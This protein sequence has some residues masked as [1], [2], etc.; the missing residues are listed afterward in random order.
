MKYLC[1]LLIAL[2]S[3][4]AYSQKIWRGLV[5]EKEN[6][7]S[8]YDKK[9]QYPYSAKIEHDIVASMNN[10]VYGPYTGKYFK[11]IKNTDIE[12]IVASSEAHNSGL[13]RASAALRAQFSQDLLN[14]TLASPA[15]NRCSTTGKCGLDAG[16][17]MPKINKCWFANRVVKI[18]QKYS[19]S[20]DSQEVR[21]LEAV[22]SNC[23]SFDMIYTARG[24]VVAT[25]APV[26]PQVQMVGQENA[27]AKYDDNDNGRIT[28]KEARNHGIAPVGK[29]HPAYKHMNDRDND[30]WVCE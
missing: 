26:A 5:V 15:V 10:Q 6:R 25:T 8:P 29:K 28:C 20:V 18:K 12:H 14:L 24:S 11:S 4:N 21:S 27:L 22:L 19:L 17:W 9:K 23:T 13:C 30:G 2:M 3:F 16:E 7:C 1:L